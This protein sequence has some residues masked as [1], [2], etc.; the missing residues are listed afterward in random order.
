MIQR[1]QQNIFWSKQFN[2]DLLR[3]L[4]VLL[5]HRR[6]RAVFLLSIRQFPD[7]SVVRT[8]RKERTRDGEPVNSPLIL[9][10]LGEQSALR[11]VITIIPSI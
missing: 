3:P 7:K 9:V 5:V 11:Y 8:V 6:R 4:I 10:N 1:K 2:A